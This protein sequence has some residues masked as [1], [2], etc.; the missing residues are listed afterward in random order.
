MRFK[1][2]SLFL[3][4][5]F[6]LM[7][8]TIDSSAQNKKVVVN[9]KAG[10]TGGTYS[11]AVTGY[12]TVDYYIKAKAGQTLS[13]KLTSSNSSLYFLVTKSGEVESITDDSRD[14]T[15]WSGELPSNDTYMVRV[16]LF[17]NAARTNKRPVN[18]KVS[19]D[20]K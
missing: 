2:Y 3:I 1:S 10:T 12:R 11:N 4:A 9:F 13:V 7:I 8:S 17:R 18:F 20:V 16:Y 14:A 6:L 5:L 19:F 15:E